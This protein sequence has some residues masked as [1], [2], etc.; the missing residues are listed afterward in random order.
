MQLHKILYGVGFTL[1]ILGMAAADS[2]WLFTPGAMFIIGLAV[3]V[4]GA[5]EDGYFK[6]GG[7][8]R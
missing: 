4:W 6:K 2:E 7:K 3:L 1:W 8:R 5:Y